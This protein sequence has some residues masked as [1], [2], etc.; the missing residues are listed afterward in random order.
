MVTTDEQIEAHFYS[1]KAYLAKGEI[2]KA[3]NS[4]RSTANLTTNETGGIQVH[5]GRHPIPEEQTGRPPRSNVWEIINDL[6]AY[7]EW[8]IRSYILLADIAAA[9]GD[10]AQ[11]KHRCSIIDNYEG[12]PELVELAQFKLEQVEEMER[13]G[14][15]TRQQ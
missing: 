2:D 15:V 10:Y 13:N 4:F 11:A 8:V 7:E 12:D 14:R 5:H 1:G 3:Y 6:P 9:K